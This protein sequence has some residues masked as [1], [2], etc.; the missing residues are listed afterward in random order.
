MWSPCV[1]GLK[2]WLIDGCWNKDAGNVE[3]ETP[4]PCGKRN[5]RSPKRTTHQLTP[6]HAHTYKTSNHANL[7]MLSTLPHSRSRTRNAQTFSLLNAVSHLL[8][9]TSLFLSV[10]LHV[11]A[12]SSSLGLNILLNAFPLYSS[13]TLPLSSSLTFT[14]SA[15]PS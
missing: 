9:P 11:F 15:F 12:L 2:A 6:N 3:R 13:S 7:Q 1:G 14:S 8:S 10:L 4:T 5:R